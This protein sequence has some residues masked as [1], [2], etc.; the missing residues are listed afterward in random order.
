MWQGPSM[1]HACV[2][3]RLGRDW[4]SASGGRA[5][6]PQD[7]PQKARTKPRSSGMRLDGPHLLRNF[8]TGYVGRKKA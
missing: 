7:H 8:P 6:V 4:L 5:S 2:P 3:D 1:R